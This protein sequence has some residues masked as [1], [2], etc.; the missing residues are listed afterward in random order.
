ML[1][2]NLDIYMSFFNFIDINANTMGVEINRSYARIAW[3]G[4]KNFI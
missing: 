4:I 2:S 1:N 3:L